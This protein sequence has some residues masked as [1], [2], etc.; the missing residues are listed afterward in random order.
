MRPH[1]CYGR[2]VAARAL[3][4]LTGLWA[5]WVAASAGADELPRPTPA[6]RTVAILILTSEKAGFNLSEVYGAT[7]RPLE[8]HTALR[9]E[10]LEAIG[11]QERQAAIRECAGDAGCFVRRLRAARDDVD[12]LLA[13]SV[14]RPDR[15]LLLGLRLIDTRRRRQIGAT[16]DEVPIG[17]SLEGVLE[18]RLPDVVPATVWDRIASVRIASRPDSAEA[19]IAGQSC[20]TPCFFDRLAPG[21]YELTVRKA[22]QTP[23]TR[24]VLLES[25]RTADIEIAL[26][27]PSSSSVFESPWFWT[28]VGAVLVAGG[29]GGYLLLQDQEREGIVCFASDP[30]DCS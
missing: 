17:M 5:A 10:P 24:W 14:D 27:N 23:K 29:V 22:G 11:L 6:P 7:R 30:A 3:L 9:V 16:G 20:V 13:V 1:R 18:E 25:G 8:R 21:S 26:E 19:S 2:V 15:E 12:L 4:A 28:A